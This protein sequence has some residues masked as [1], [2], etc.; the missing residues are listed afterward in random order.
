MGTDTVPTHVWKI[1]HKVF[2][3]SAP[4]SM[5]LFTGRSHQQCMIFLMAAAMVMNSFPEVWP[6]C[7]RKFS[8]IRASEFGSNILSIMYTVISY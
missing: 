4:K 6:N 2:F 8:V 7:H 3:E 5:K 1:F